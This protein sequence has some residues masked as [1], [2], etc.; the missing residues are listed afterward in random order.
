MHARLVAL[1]VAVLLLLPA[2]AAAEQTFVE[3]DGVDGQGRFTIFLEKT[4]RDSEDYVFFLRAAR[5]TSDYQWRQCYNGPADA[6][7]CERDLWVAAVS[8]PLGPSGDVLVFLI[9]VIDGRKWDLRLLGLFAAV[10]AGDSFLTS[11]PPSFRLGVTGEAVFVEPYPSSGG[12]YFGLTQARV[13]T[14]P[15]GAYSF[16]VFYTTRVPD[17]RSLLDLLPHIVSNV[18][19]YDIVIAEPVR[20]CG[21]QQVAGGDA[22]DTRLFDVGR[23]SGR[24]QFDYET[25]SQK[26]RIVVR[27]EGKT[28]FDTGCVGTSG[29]VTVPFS[30]SFR[31]IQVDVFPNC[32]GGQG[33]QWNYTVHC[34]V[35]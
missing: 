29:S 28:L 30:G 33:T 16:Y 7:R 17:A 3:L 25:F 34:A 10:R 4:P 8:P 9:K 27:Y 1:A 19:R 13:N 20:V 11:V 26:D 35:P 31:Q 18:A 2:P 23:N 14:L 24:F 12:V 5:I 32:A 15:P 21:T 22:A 6:E